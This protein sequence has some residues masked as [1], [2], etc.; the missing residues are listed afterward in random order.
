MTS[1]HHHLHLGGKVR[2]MSKKSRGCLLGAPLAKSETTCLFIDN[3]LLQYIMI[4]M[5]YNL[6]N[7]INYQPILKKI[8]E[9]LMRSEIITV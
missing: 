5:N 1:T 7:E 8:V 9:S 3:L 2:D 6:L 4:M